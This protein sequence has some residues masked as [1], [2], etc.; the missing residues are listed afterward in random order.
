MK[1]AKV[2]SNKEGEVS[3]VKIE[4]L[5]R[6]FSYNGV[7]L[8]DP[9]MEYGPD[10]VRDIYSANFPELVTAVVEGPEKSGNGLLYTFRKSVGE[11][12]VCGSRCA[13]LLE[14]GKPA[15]QK[16]YD[17]SSLGCACK[18]DDAPCGCKAAALGEQGAGGEPKAGQGKAGQDGKHI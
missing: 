7:S 1:T 16:G 15:G 3:A 10:Q 2:F 11:K 18:K 4:Q 8:P 14:V 6:R 17:A 12:G 5:E 13:R 9:G